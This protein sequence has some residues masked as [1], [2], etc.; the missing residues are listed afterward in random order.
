MSVWMFNDI[1]IAMSKEIVLWFWRPNFNSEI[2][3]CNLNF[4][5]LINNI[6]KLKQILK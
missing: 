6:K 1:F 3:Q 4:A 5:I 2:W